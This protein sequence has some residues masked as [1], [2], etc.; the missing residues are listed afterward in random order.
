MTSVIEGRARSAQEPHGLSWTEMG[1]GVWL[2]KRD[3]D[4]AGIIE[5]LWGAGYRVT[6][7]LGRIVCEFATFESARR[8]LE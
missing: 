2:A 7:R 4:F 6:D 5:K 3:A 8:N 1:V